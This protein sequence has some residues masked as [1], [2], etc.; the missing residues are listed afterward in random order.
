MRLVLLAQA[1]SSRSAKSAWIITGTATQEIQ[2][3][4]LRLQLNLAARTESAGHPAHA[5]GQKFAHEQCAGDLLQILEDMVCWAA[6]WE[7]SAGSFG[8]G[9]CT[10]SPGSLETAPQCHGPWFLYWRDRPGH[11][12]ERLTPQADHY[13]AAIGSDP[14]RN[15][16]TFPGSASHTGVN[17]MNHPMYA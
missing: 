13:G 2:K 15:R 1:G 17:A 16:C 4:I 12:P 10:P 11:L 7:Q 5:G 14:D 6:R 3:N 9:C 8:P